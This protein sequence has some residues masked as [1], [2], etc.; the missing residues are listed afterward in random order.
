MSK[1]PMKGR[2]T[3]IFLTEGMERQLER[4]HCTLTYAIYKG[5]KLLEMEEKIFE[6]KKKN[7]NDN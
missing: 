2:R 4:Y 6:E 5:F 3:S 1:K 7:G